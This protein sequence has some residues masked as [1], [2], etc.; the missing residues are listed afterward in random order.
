M[1]DLIPLQEREILFICSL[2][3]TVLHNVIL[4]MHCCESELFFY[5]TQSTPGNR[6]GNM[7][8]GRWGGR[9]TS[10]IIL[11]GY[12]WDHA[13]ILKWECEM[14]SLP[15]SWISITA[16]LMNKRKTRL[17]NTCN[18]I[19]KHFFR[20]YNPWALFW[21]HKRHISFDYYMGRWLREIKG[22]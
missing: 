7:A 21:I 5:F 4:S 10:R 8:Q 13:E 2:L 3:D 22:T 14:V 11:R 16:P 19:H 15:K 6:Q 17:R 12:F 9:W 20:T 1:F 18:C